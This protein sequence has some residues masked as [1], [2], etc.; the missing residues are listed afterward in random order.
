MRQRTIGRL[1]LVPLLLVFAQANAQT[2]P[3]PS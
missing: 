1:V 3:L 2:D